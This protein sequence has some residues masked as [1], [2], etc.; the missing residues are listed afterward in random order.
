MYYETEYACSD[1][2]LDFLFELAH[3][4]R[5]N[6]ILPKRHINDDLFRSATMYDSPLSGDRYTPTY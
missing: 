3:S 5:A 2:Y 4:R 6:G 1:H